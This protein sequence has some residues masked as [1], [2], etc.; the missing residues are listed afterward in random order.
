MEINT[1]PDTDL[2]GIIDSLDLDSDGDGCPDAL[3]GSGTFTIADLVTST[4]DG[5]N[6]NDGSY[7]GT[8]TGVVTDAIVENLGITVDT[9]TTSASFG[10]PIIAG[11]GQDV[12]AS[13]NA[14]DTSSCPLD[15]EAFDD[16]QTTD[17]DVSVVV[18]ILVNDLGTDT[19]TSISII[20][21]PTNGTCLLYTSPSPRDS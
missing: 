2:D 12:G 17:E 21:S 14:S 13:Q 19:I 18:D 4:I 9:D 15:L 10:V 11:I 3:E 8:Y 7:N 16:S 5:G 6:N 20:D 1:C